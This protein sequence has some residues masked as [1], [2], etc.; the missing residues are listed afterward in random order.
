M[1]RKITIVLLVLFMI[2]SS[3]IPSK[4]NL[5]YAL[6]DN[7]INAETKTQDIVK[8][9]TTTDVDFD[10]TET[11]IISEV[12]SERTFNS[13]TFLRADGTYEVAVYDTNVHYNDNGVWKE[14]DNSLSETENEFAIKD[15]S[16][17]LKFPKTIE[18]NKDIKLSMGDYSIDWSIQAT[19]SS[20]AIYSDSVKKSA[21]I[22]E[23]ACVNQAIVYNDIQE[24]VDIEYIVSGNEVK[25]N[26][27]LNKYIE[28]YSITFEYKVKNL[29]IIYD[30]S[31][32]ILFI[33]GENEII[34]KFSDV[35]MFDAN[36]Q[37]SYNIDFEIISTKQNTYKITINPDE[38]YLMNA[39]YPVVID[40][41]ISSVENEEIIIQDTYYNSQDGNSPSDTIIVCGENMDNIG[42]INFAVPSTLKN[43]KIIFA[44]LNLTTTPTNTGGELLVHEIN[45]YTNL[46]DYPFFPSILPGS[47]I[48]R[49]SIN[50]NSHS[51][52]IDIT[53][54]VNKWNE[55]ELENMPG[56][57]L[58]VDD[59]DTTIDEIIFWSTNAM[60]FVDCLAAEKPFISIGYYEDEDLSGI[61]DFWTYNS[62]EIGSAGT[63]YISDYTQQLY[64]IRTDFLYQSELQ[65]LGI[66][67]AYS[68]N[69]AMSATPNIG[70]GNGWNVNYNLMLHFDTSNEE[71]YSVDFTGNK[72]N[73]HELDGCDSRFGQDD[74]CYIAEDGSGNVLVDFDTSSTYSGA[75]IVTS[76]GTMYNF[77]IS[78]GIETYLEMIYEL[79]TDLEITVYRP[80]S[81]SKVISYVEDSSDN[82]LDFNYDSNNRLECITLMTKN[83]SM[84]H[85]LERVYYEYYSSSNFLH[86]IY[87]LT[88]YD[89]DDDLTLNTSDLTNVDKIVRYDHNPLDLLY[90]GFVKYINE[91][92]G[93]ESLGEEIR[94]Y[95]YSGDD[96]KVKQ[97]DSFFD[98]TKYSQ[99]NYDNNYT[100]TK[101]SDHSGNFV[102]YSF[103]TYGHTISIID[104]DAN[105]LYYSYID[106]FRMHEIMGNNDYDYNLNHTLYSES[107]PSIPTSVGVTN[108][109]FEDGLVDWD[110]H[111]FPV[112]DTTDFIEINNSEHTSGLHSVCVHNELSINLSQSWLERS[113]TLGEGYY[114]ISIDVKNDSTETGSSA[115]VYVT[116]NNETKEV[117]NDGE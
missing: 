9:P 110:T 33:N 97:I 17:K 105:A 90:R 75:S 24:D 101:I 79:Y 116:V 117:V 72:V 102:L 96:Y 84:Y 65:T 77:N 39:S 71:I 5:V 95:Y 73:Y 45:N 13:K 114:K 51:Y 1:T 27:I 20:T 98:D 70:Y 78:C 86:D 54:S 111:V 8:Y 60:S 10:I 74:V 30:I 82:Q 57:H 19:Q 46:N 22:S 100:Q 37:L 36:N 29:S 106:I 66:S 58:T 83:S 40:P 2:A 94:Y 18:D 55:L 104:K 108:T 47:L 56:F 44:T 69:M 85:N 28:N 64:I 43:H 6:D 59:V 11:N 48:N 4:H 16:F 89:I 25:E 38:D 21:N 63:G 81:T 112:Y 87:Y 23:L 52:H 113:I 7:Y 88:D 35:Y 31:G 91:S 103:D 42:L 32:D 14:I 15:N 80:N 62:Q 53:Y 67:F 26:I 3:I 61:K 49:V 92:T 99:V 107:S 68:N 50:P 76:E 34:F 109:S 12:I 41:T 115:R 93:I